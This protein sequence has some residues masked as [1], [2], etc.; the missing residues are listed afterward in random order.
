MAFTSDLDQLL[1]KQGITHYQFRR[2]CYRNNKNPMP[3]ITRELQLEIE[4]EIPPGQV[5]REQ[6]VKTWK[7][8]MLEVNRLLYAP[9]APFDLKIQQV[10]Q[11]RLAGKTELHITQV[12]GKDYVDQVRRR[13][14]IQTHLAKGVTPSQLAQDYDLTPAA[15]T[16]MKPEEQRIRKPRLSDEAR[17][18]ICTNTSLS[19]QQLAKKHGTTINT[20]YKI[21]REWKNL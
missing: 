13:E 14:E 15:I 5:S 8:T 6:L 12:Y 2:W 7:L 16:Y 20:V 10:H 1:A 4:A 18:D 17:L 9:I 11:D 3:P 21:K 19:I